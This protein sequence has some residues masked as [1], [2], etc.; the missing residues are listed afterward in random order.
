MRIED[1]AKH[2][3]L[4][5]VYEELRNAVD[6]NRWLQWEHLDQVCAEM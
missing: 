1:Y 6:T 2:A 5:V 3:L 4:G